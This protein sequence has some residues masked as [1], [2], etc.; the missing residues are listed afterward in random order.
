MKAPAAITIDVE[1]DWGGRASTDHAVCQG[2]EEGLPKI[3]GILERHCVRATFFVSGKFAKRHSA[4]VPSLVNESHGVASHG[5]DHNMDYAALSSS[6]LI[7]QLAKSKDILEEK[8]NS[9]IVGFRSPRFRIHPE[10]FQCLRKTGYR[11]DSSVITARVGKKGGANADYRA[12]AARNGIREI[13]I[14]VMPIFNM[15]FGLL[16]VNLI[17]WKPASFALKCE[18]SADAARIMYAHP[19]D[20][21]A[22]K[23]FYNGISN[24]IRLWYNWRGHSAEKTFDRIVR[25]MKASYDIKLMREISSSMPSE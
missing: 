17:G 16:W 9:A 8:T 20:L 7:R 11:Y 14:Y 15:P 24:P 19:F 18:R 6:E 13:P 3:L 22:K 2:L 21:V 1:T 25:F 5:Y 4:V 12:E 23:L 10:L